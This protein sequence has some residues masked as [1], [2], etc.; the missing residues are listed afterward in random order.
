MDKP[1]E[2]G[3]CDPVTLE[4]VKGS[5][6]AAQAEMEALLERTSMS[7]VIRE[8][9]DYFAGFFDPA[10]KMIAGTNL[11]IFGHIVEPFFEHYP[12][13]TMRAGDIYWYNDCYAS[14]GG[15]SHSPDQV[16]VAPVMVDGKLAGFSQSWAHFKD[17]GG[18]WPGSMSPQATDIYQEGII[19]PPV[20][21]AREGV[22]NDE[23]M[24]IFLRNGR[25]PDEQQ[26]DLRA[27]TA[28]VKLGERRLLELFER[29]GW[30]VVQ[31]AFVRLN[32]QTRAAVVKQLRSTFRTGRYSFTDQVDSDGLGNGP[33]AIRFDMDV[34]DDAI[35][36]DT[37][38]SDPQARGP[39]NFLMNPAVPKMVFGIYALAN[40][41]SLLLNEGAMHAVD[42]V[43]VKEGTI[44]QPK[45]PGPL[46]QRGL[47]LLR[48][49]AVCAGLMNVASGGQG[50]AATN[51]Y[52]IIFLRGHDPETKAPFLLSDGIGVGH[53]ARPFADGHDAV[54]YVA[55]EN[56]PAEFM[57][58]VY[59][60]RLVRYGLHC[61]SGGPGR[62]RGGT[63]VV[64]E[65]MWLGEDAVLAIRLDGMLN[66]PWGV[67]GGQSG[68]PGRCWINPDAPDG[69]EVPG[70][71]SDGT[72]VKRGDVIRVLTGGGGGW[73]HPFD[74]ESERVLEDVRGGA[75]SIDG[76]RD[77]YGVVIDPE[78]MT[79]DAAATAVR[80]RDH[81][82]D[83]KLFHRRD[84]VEAMV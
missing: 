4:I 9:K 34:S 59:P 75:V 18:A 55:Q 12:S 39:V 25:F 66:P 38:R 26:G 30:D 16:F 35:T 42:A 11:P 36:I 10:G 29:F 15:V 41:P 22:M 50:P 46:N 14:K 37:S 3:R 17:I 24:R 79:L 19:I 71:L 82:P 64:R 52:S 44:V 31:D 49:Q 72:V 70:P 33:F 65:V 61:D 20:R 6:R 80:R 83:A 27:L 84:Y 68:R 1:V 73:G 32:E 78:T 40:D 45:F 62:W 7:P 8:K 69:R 53:G 77:D 21:L 58:Q 63:G 48:V 28:A 51:A 47:T 60:A 54:Y 57:D 56:T 5:I 2:A 13:Q 76:A 43:V 23:I 81:R 74:R 67:S